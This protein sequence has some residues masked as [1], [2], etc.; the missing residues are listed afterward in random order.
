MSDKELIRELVNL[1]GLAVDSQRWDLFDRIFYR[2]DLRG[3][4]D[5][6]LL[7]LPTDQI[8]G[9]RGRVDRMEPLP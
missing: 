8:E 5:R 3:I 1:Y 7:F 4:H 6:A 9:V 2:V